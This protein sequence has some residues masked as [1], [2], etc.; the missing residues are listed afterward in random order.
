MKKASEEHG[1]E[2]LS[3]MKGITD[4]TNTKIYEMEKTLATLVYNIQGFEMKVN[5]QSEAQKRA[6]AE[7]QARINNQISA[8]D[9]ERKKEVEELKRR[10]EQFQK[11][12]ASRLDTAAACAAPCP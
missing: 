4:A 6:E 12:E 9:A 7:Y 3:I 5:E 2:I 1:K 11:E 8:I 10:E